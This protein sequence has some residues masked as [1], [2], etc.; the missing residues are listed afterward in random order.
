MSTGVTIA[1]IRAAAPRFRDQARTARA[2]ESI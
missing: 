2:A 1:A